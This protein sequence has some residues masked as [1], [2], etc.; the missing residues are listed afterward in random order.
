MGGGEKMGLKGIP[1]AEITALFRAIGS[2]LFLLAA[3]IDLMAICGLSQVEW[4][5]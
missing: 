2:T 4:Q 3:L 5:E 1:K